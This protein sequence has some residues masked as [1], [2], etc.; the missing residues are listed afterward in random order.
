VP[1]RGG[2]HGKPKT[3]K[4]LFKKI[5]TNS[6]E[7]SEEQKREPQEIIPDLVIDGRF[8]GFSL[9]GVG[10]ILF[11]HTRTLVD[12]KTKSCDDK[13]PAAPGDPAA[14]AKN[15]RRRST[16][17]ITRGRRNWTRSSAQQQARRGRSQTSSTSTVRRAE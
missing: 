2:F 7:Q 13:Y 5:N 17:T 9:D 10:V 16:T 8:L 12:V 1:H 6:D 14:V 11:R 3:C 15:G 4:D